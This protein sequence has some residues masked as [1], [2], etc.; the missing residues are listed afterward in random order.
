MPPDSNWRGH[1]IGDQ[2]TTAG[3]RQTPKERKTRERRQENDLGA[4]EKENG[5]SIN[6]SN[7]SIETTMEPGE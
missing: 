2:A 7:Q 1:R 3:K 6:Q 5:H 4:R